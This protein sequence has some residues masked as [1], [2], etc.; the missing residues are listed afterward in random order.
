MFHNDL[1]PQISHGYSVLYLYFIFS[2]YLIL[3]RSRRYTKVSISLIVFIIVDG[4]VMEMNAQMNNMK[5]QLDEIL[6]CN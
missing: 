1:Y 4:N 3:F 5:D 6:I 2:S